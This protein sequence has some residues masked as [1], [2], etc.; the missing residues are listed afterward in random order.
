MGDCLHYFDTL[1]NL[2]SSMPDAEHPALEISGTESCRCTSH[3]VLK[4]NLW[5]CQDTTALIYSPS[6]F[7]KNMHPMHLIQISTTVSYYRCSFFSMAVV[8]VQWKYLPSQA[9]VC[10]GPSCSKLMTSSVNETLKFQT[11]ISQICQNFC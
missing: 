6:N 8:R 4:Y 10:S 1:I 11:L 3:I 5:P 2:K 7:T 9:A